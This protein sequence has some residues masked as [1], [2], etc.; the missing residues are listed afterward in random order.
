MARGGINKA[1]VKDAR[2]GILLW[3]D[4]PSIDTIRVELGNTGSKTT[5]HR[6][7]KELEEEEGTRLD[8][9][10]L[11]SDTL[12]QMVAKLASQ[13]QQ[14]A[15]HIVEQSSEL[16]KQQSDSLHKQINEL[17][18]Q[19]KA[20]T[21]QLDSTTAA[22]LST[23]DELQNANQQCQVESTKC[24]ELAEKLS[25]LDIRL[26][27]KVL[28]IQSLEEKHQHARDALEHFRQSAKEQR[29][30]EILRH[31]HQIQQIQAENR[32]LNQ[33]LSVKHDEIT[34]LNKD[35][36]RFVTQFQE[37]QKQL[38]E[39]TRIND[40]FDLKLK[41]SVQVESNVSNER[42]NLQKQLNL[43]KFETQQ[44]QAKNRVMTEKLGQE[45]EQINQDNRSKELEITKLQAE[46]STRKAIFSQLK[47]TKLALS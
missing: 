28:H 25:A 1:L 27:D 5:I 31:E 46:L 43:V 6:Y 22:L 18:L 9:T 29:E 37:N 20:L 23:Q 12:K 24:I 36:G 10:A 2:D 3:G 30:Q 33:T 35:N 38:A 8:D 26:T 14:E 40:A 21:E 44:Q 39:V 34:Q 15:K 45:L 4:N 41:K 47:N 17:D 7:L 13:L 19:I 42:D 32:Q 16:H 11:L